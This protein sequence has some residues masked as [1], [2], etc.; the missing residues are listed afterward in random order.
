MGIA[1]SACTYLEDPGVAD[2]AFAEIDVSS[3][4]GVPHLVID[5]KASSPLARIRKQES[6]YGNG[7][8]YDHEEG[9]V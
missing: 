7:E 8:N 3:Q 6:E 4:V 2:I 9:G 5:Q 1:L